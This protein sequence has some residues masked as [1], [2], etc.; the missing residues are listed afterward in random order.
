MIVIVDSCEVNLSWFLGYLY[1]VI[2]ED[3]FCVFPLKY[4]PMYIS[5]RTGSLDFSYFPSHII[6]WGNLLMFLQVIAGNMMINIFYQ[7]GVEQLGVTQLP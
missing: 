2:N 3:Y 7:Q 5:R 6:P 4:R 1:L